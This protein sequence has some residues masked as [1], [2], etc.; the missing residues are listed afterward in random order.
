MK[1]A[2]V[3][4]AARVVNPNEGTAT[5]SDKLARAKAVAAGHE[6][7]PVVQTDP[8]V[9]QVQESQRKRIKM[10]TQRS[11]DRHSQ[12][13]QVEPVAQQT[14]EPT[15]AAPGDT[16]DSTEPVK[17]TSDGTKP[18]DPQ[19]VAL[20]KQKR[21]IQLAQKALDDAKSAFETEKQGLLNGYVSKESLKS[22]AL[23][24]LLAEGVTYDQ[25]TEEILASG[26]ENAD[27]SAIRAEIK[28]LKEGFDT[29]LT[30][31]DAQTEKQVLAQIRNDVDQLIATGDDYETVREAGYAPK[32]VEL[33]H[34][35]YKDEG[36]MLEITEA[37]SLIEREALAD[38]LKWAKIKKVQKQLNPAPTQQ[39]TPVQQDK[40]GTKIMRTLTNRDGASSAS[41]NRR[42]RAIA[43]AEG[44]LKS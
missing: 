13:A 43:A 6:P 38:A 8:Q 5:S 19:F 32:V 23:K 26:Q 10:T 34:R 11:P 20:A 33:I 39:T 42:E 36:K 30:E 37:A 44:R 27:L 4:G 21:E 40:P 9:L 29:Q 3:T 17:P 14:V 24:T 1:I 18:L 22:S 16:L 31:R 28:A 7:A 35:V 41:M 15:A 12:A 2:P 25:L